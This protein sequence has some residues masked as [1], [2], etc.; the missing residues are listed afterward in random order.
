MCIR[1]KTYK[2]S[3]HFVVGDCK[4]KVLINQ[5]LFKLISGDSH[6]NIIIVAHFLSLAMSLMC[7]YGCVQ[8]YTEMSFYMYM[9]LAH[10]RSMECLSPSLPPT[11]V[12]GLHASS[13][14]V[15]H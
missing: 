10:A 15:L 13:V 3:P 5:A 2:V 11:I 1:T 9:L 7:N 6:N 8:F 4:I 12:A 14:N